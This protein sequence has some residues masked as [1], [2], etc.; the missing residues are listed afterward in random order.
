MAHRKVLLYGSGLF[1]EVG[2]DSLLPNREK[3]LQFGYNLTLLI[4]GNILLCHSNLQHG[5][6]LLVL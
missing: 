2:V 5:A 4:T 1:L 3:E 6:S